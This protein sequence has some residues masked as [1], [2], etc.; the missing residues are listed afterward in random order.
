MHDLW[1]IGEIVRKLRK[2]KIHKTQEQFAELID[3]STDT[4]SNI[5]RGIVMPNTKTL[6]NIAEACN[7]SIDYILGTEPEDEKNEIFV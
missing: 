6:I 3:V 1:T 5:E 4:V 2:E 7:V